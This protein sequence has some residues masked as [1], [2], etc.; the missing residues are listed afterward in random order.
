[1][2]IYSNRIVTTTKI[3]R[4]TIIT[5]VWGVPDGISPVCDG[6]SHRYIIPIS[7]HFTQPEQTQSSSLSRFKS[8]TVPIR[9]VATDRAPSNRRR[10]KFPIYAFYSC[11]E[12][13]CAPIRA[14]S[15]CCIGTFKRK[16]VIKCSLFTK[17]NIN[18]SIC[19]ALM[20]IYSVCT[21][22]ILLL[23]FVFSKLCDQF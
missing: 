20:Y 22:N 4:I 15:S 19:G 9:Y 3:S 5:G 1:M 16:C 2:Q 10:L 12:S 11:T 17:P 21:M 18:P 6:I 8:K 13:S 23:C 7:A 14:N